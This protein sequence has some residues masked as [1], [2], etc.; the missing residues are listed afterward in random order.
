MGV[1]SVGLW[2]KSTGDA[3]TVIHNRTA[4]KNFILRVGGNFMGREGDPAKLF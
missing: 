4:A 3:A 1:V 2:D